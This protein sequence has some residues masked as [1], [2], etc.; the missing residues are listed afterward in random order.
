MYN[1]LTHCRKR[2]NSA[3]TNCRIRGKW[4]WFI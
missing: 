1:I 2:R 4:F 3:C